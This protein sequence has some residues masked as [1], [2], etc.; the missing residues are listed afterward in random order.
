MSSTR[1]PP[2][3]CAASSPCAPPAQASAPSPSRSTRRAFC[4]P[5]RSTISARGAATRATSTTSGRKPPSKLS[6][7]ARSILGTW[8]RAKP[9][10]FPI[11]PASSSTSRRRNGY[12]WR[13]PT[14]PSFPARSGIPWSASTKRRCARRRP[15]TAS[16]ASS[17]VL[18]TVP[19]VASKC[20]TTSSASP[21]RTERRGGTAPL[22]A[23]TMPEA[24]K[25]PAPSTPSMRM[26]WRSWC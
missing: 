5:V 22:S 20:V 2:L 17:P 12:G 3:P 15:R 8:C 4:R 10:H 11:S 19:T 13:E 9:A 14:N 24:A 23:A 6:S 18:S 7:A 21:I 1:R 16:A 26:C 25:A